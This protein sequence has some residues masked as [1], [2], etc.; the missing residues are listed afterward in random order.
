MTRHR[1]IMTLTATTL[2]A[3]AALALAGPAA[4]APTRIDL[5]DGWQPEGV[6]TDG[7]RVYAGS[8]ADGGLAV[9]NPRTGR[10]R[11][12]HE[13]RDGWGSVGVEYDRRRDLV[14]AAGGPTGVVRAH[15]ADTGRVRATYRFPT[16]EPTFL[17]DLV[18]TREGVFVTDSMTQRLAVLPF[19]DGGGLP[20][21]GSVE[22]LPL[23]GDL[24][25]EDGFNL[26]G[27]VRYRGH[28]LV[29][30]S[31]TGLLFRVDDENGHTQ[32]VRLGGYRVTNG[33]GLELDGRTLY[34]VRNQLNRI[35]VIRLSADGSRGRAV[36][37][38]L[39]GGFDVPTTVAL[40]GRSLWAA[41]A[42]FGT[43]PTPDTEYW[44]SRVR[45][46]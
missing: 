40:V 4:A 23:T 6:T 25:Y 29:V 32:R 15:D 34:A 31:N 28:L 8:L 30:Q 12:L 44:L 42:R 2:G 21:P 20:R 24:A 39:S 3:A 13:G 18:V 41:N 16:T 19:R 36:A 17:N 27:I 14:W 1:W 11:V 46:Y 22:Y 43:P 5:P 7:R 37:E 10:V 38:L 9:A 35:A 45:P 33:D 26:N